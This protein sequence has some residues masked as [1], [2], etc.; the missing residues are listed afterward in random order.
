MRDEDARSRQKN[1]PSRLEPVQ[2][3]LE[4]WE[5]NSPRNAPEDPDE[6]GGETAALGELQGHN[7]SP[8]ED[9]KQRDDAT[10]ASYRDTDP[11]G[12]RVEQDMSRPVEG[13]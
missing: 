10:N 6:P 2:E 1:L 9:G 12:H 4:Q 13:C 8:E 3:H 5:E 11:G 7:R